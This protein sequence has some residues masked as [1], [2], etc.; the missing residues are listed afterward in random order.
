M[1]DFVLARDNYR[2]VEQMVS[3]TWL[4]RWPDDYT[5]LDGADPV[6]EKPARPKKPHSKE[7]D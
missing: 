7:Q 2:G 5:V 4:A 6:P 3:T 1:P